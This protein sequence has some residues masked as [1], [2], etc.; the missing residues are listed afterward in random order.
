MN[1]PDCGNPVEKEAQFCPKCFAR[2]EPPS[3]WRRFLSLFQAAGKPRGPIIDI[4]KSVTIKTT[5]EAGQQHEYHSLEEVPPE[6]RAELEKLE[7]EALRE[8]FRYSSSSADGLTTKVISQK[9]G[10]KN[11]SIF[12][13]T[14]AEG[15]ERIYHSLEELPPEIRA[16]FE[17]AQKET[18]E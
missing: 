11:V 1:C 8:D 16:A 10:Q 7:S 14:D 13:V 17:Q 2:L 4:T 12:K 18:K 3:L 6:L 9:S 5:D 15:N